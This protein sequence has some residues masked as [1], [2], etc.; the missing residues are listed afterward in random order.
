VLAVLRDTLGDA[1]VKNDRLIYVWLLDYSPQNWRQRTLAAL[2]FFYWRVGAGSRTPGK[3]KVKPL[4]DFTAPV[5]PVLSQV[6]NSLLQ[7]TLLDPMTPAV[8]ASS[9]AYRENAMDSQ[10]IHLEQAISYVSEAPSGSGTPEGLTQNEI[11]LLLARLSLRKR[12]LG[13]LIPNERAQKIG[14]A[15]QIDAERIRVRNWEMLRQAA[16]KTGLIFE[17]LTL[18]GVREDYAM[19]WFR[20]DTLP[21]APSGDMGPIWKIL[22]IQNPWKDQRLRNWKG[23]TLDKPVDGS[24]QTS[25]LIPLA[26]YS[27]TYPRMPLL[28]V[29]FR[30]ESHVRRHEIAQRGV[31]QLVNGVLGLSH[32][33]NWYYF[34]GADIYSFVTSRQGAAQNRAARLDSYVQ[35]RTELALDTELPSELRAEMQRRVSDLAVNPLE[36]S[37]QA[38]LETAH[39]RYIN[40]QQ[41]ASNG[42]LMKLLN[43]QRREEIAEYGKGPGHLAMDEVLHATS[44]GLYTHRARTNSDLLAVLDR[45]RRIQTNLEYLDQ[46]VSEGLKPEVGFDRARITESVNE[47]TT[48]LPGVQSERVRSRAIADLDRIQQLTSDDQL[49]SDCLFAL[50]SLRGAN[51]PGVTAQ[52][53][54]VHVGTNTLESVK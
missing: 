7:W 43:L 49:R 47:V 12:T 1:D 44:F 32:F 5:H 48:L 21:L 34:A 9:R 33:A 42:T 26:A 13:G 4:L 11:D 40:L 22:N 30:S 37:P 8:R 53:R 18:S 31:N 38:E 23:L 24:G 20:S 15:E 6:N 28:V 16:E 3:G 54:I 51:V 17:P 25:R 46:V 41:E 45:N 14:D 52:P 27:L 10:R 39:A 2:P 35:F 50:R 36:A 29:D 19:L